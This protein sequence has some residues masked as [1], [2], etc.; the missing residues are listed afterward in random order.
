MDKDKEVRQKI[1]SEYENAYSE[2]AGLDKIPSHIKLSSKSQSNKFL[3]ERSCFYRLNN[4]MTIRY[5]VLT[6][7]TNYQSVVFRAM[8]NGKS[9]IYAILYYSEDILQSYV[10]LGPSLSSSDGEYRP[11]VVRLDMLLEYYQLHTEI[12]E[13][14]EKHIR[15]RLED[16]L[17]L[18]AM[19]FGD[20]TASSEKITQT[21]DDS[22]YT[23][24]F[25]SYVWLLMFWQYKYDMLPNHIYKPF[26]DII[27]KDSDILYKALASKFG[28]DKLFE[29]IHYSAM[30]FHSIEF[31]KR[32]TKSSL[33]LGHKLIP[34][35]IVDVKNFKNPKYRPWRELY[36]DNL[37][38]KLVV[39]LITPG[40]PF[41][42]DYFFI[43][44]SDHGMF[45]NDS[46]HTKLDYSI[47]GENIVQSLV[48]TQKKTSKT[49]SES[50]KYE[51]D[52]D[53]E[54]QYLNAKFKAI[55]DQLENTIEFT[56]EELVMSGVTM[57]KIVENIGFTIRDIVRI[58]GK[59]YRTM[60]GPLLTDPAIFSK[61]MFEI[62]Y[63]LACLNSKIGII[64]GDLHM[65]NAV[66]NPVVKSNHTETNAVILYE[67]DG[68]YYKFPH[69]GA[70]GGIIDFSRAI[71]QE[72]QIEKDF[73]KEFAEEYIYKQRSAILA[74][75]KTF[76]PDFYEKHS[77]KLIESLKTKYDS[78]FKIV[79]AI[80]TY[81]VMMDLVTIL[82]SAKENTKIHPKNI[83]LIEKIR[84]MAQTMLTQ[85]MQALLL[86]GIETDYPN[87]IIV[88][89][90]F[91]EFIVDK[92]ESMETPCDLFSYSRP[93]K[94]DS[95]K[96]SEF[97]EFLK[98]K[99]T[100]QVFAKF[101]KPHDLTY[102]YYSDYWK[103]FPKDFT[104]IVKNLR[105][106]KLPHKD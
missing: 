11:Y 12:Y 10:A 74:I 101:K 75:Y 77:V 33:R 98:R 76:F 69:Y 104:D 17:E 84:N 7:K 87:L 48:D 55:S 25:F 32:G 95:T 41:M 9:T 49:T 6:S 5:N 46:M 2:Y 66:I 44:H 93:M 106:I 8:R 1:N 60:I 50:S 81:R 3:Y 61:Y 99:F 68:S 47:V 78:V 97:P 21:C 16:D 102:K 14:I 51:L 27:F 30:F 89:E 26:V 35:T 90:C 79:S 94:Y 4:L 105:A 88:K 92:L 80:D 91:K 71:I 82:K 58:G 28:E 24:I 64:Q 45:D 100:E 65:N 13:E 19:I 29:V 20:N 23:I 15:N 52:S 96:E 56:K 18:M 83:A 42:G 38:G 63:T 67:I 39:N 40:V 72:S 70:Y 73:G 31:L 85:N 22:R 37:V 36:V 43:K 54:I 103:N 57:C 34:L 53:D 62:V 59:D 86:G